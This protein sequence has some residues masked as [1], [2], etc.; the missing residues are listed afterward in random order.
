MKFAIVAVVVIVV[1]TALI[2][3]VTAKVVMSI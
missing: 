2:V 3:A 1:Y